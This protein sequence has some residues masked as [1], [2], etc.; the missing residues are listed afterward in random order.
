MIVLL[1]IVVCLPTLWS[2]FPTGFYASH[3]GAYHLIRLIHFYNEMVK[4]QFPVRMGAELAYGYGYPIFNYM[5]PLANILGS[6]FHFLGFDYGNSLKLVIGLA[7]VFS[8][9]FYYF[10]LRIDFKKWPALVGAVLS[11]YV[12]YRLV[13]MYVSGS[14][15]IVLSFLFLPIILW[16]VTQFIKKGKREGWLVVGIAGLIL[17]HNVSVLIYFPFVAVYTLVIVYFNRNLVNITKLLFLV[18]LGVGISSFFW[19]PAVLEMNYVNLGRGIAVNYLDHFPSL[20]QLVYSPWGYGYSNG[21]N[22]GMSFQIGIAQWLV[23]GISLTTSV[24]LLFKKRLFKK[25]NLVPL[26]FLLM[27]ILTVVI[28]LPISTPLWRSFKLIDQLQFPWRFLALF[29]PIGAYLA[30]WSTTKTKW[31]LGILL[32]ILALYSNRNYLRT[33]EVARYPDGFYIKQTGLFHGSTDIAWEALPVWTKG[34]IP[35]SRA[36]T[37]IRENENSFK[38]TEESVTRGEKIKLIINNNEKQEVVFNLFYFPNWQVFANNQELETKASDEGMLSTTL[39]A[40]DYELIVKYA[41]TP[42][43][44]LA[45]WISLVSLL[46]FAIIFLMRRTVLF[47]FN[48]CSPRKTGVADKTK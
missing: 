32:I 21:T 38:Y 8:V 9:V 14:V 22:G 15:G 47:L 1:L 46:V 18:L 30:S 5:Y 36:K 35:S 6:G 41:S 23:T 48:S 42:T 10:W 33:W 27:F 17:S 3:D 34:Q 37:V 45:N 16:S 40:G 13:A 25:E 11:T 39:P 44:I 31:W 43:Q 2:L 24:W 19:I 29:I 7:T 20:R 4:G 28:I 12:P 26:S